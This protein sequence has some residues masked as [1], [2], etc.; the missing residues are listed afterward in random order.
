MCCCCMR[1]EQGSIGTLLGI[2]FTKAMSS[3]SATDSLLTA[4]P[5][6]AHRR[7]LFLMAELASIECSENEA[8]MTVRARAAPDG[9]RRLASN[10]L[11]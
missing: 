4:E 3:F 6:D 9:T 8:S 7:H 1:G 5:R 2:F 11:V 10:A